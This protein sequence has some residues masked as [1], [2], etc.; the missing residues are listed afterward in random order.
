VSEDER[1]TAG[2][3]PP[4]AVVVR[5]GIMLLKDL[6]GNVLSHYDRVLAE[7]GRE[8]WALSVN[9]IPDLS[10]EDVARRAG[11]LNSQICVSTVGAIRALDYEVR[12]D[13]KENGHSNI[14]FD[15]EPTDEDLLRVRSAFSDPIPNPARQI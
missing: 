8:E 13:W 9:C 14:V 5:G 4:D 6:Q 11:R 12:P 7:E 15:G 3:L 2:D 10:A 1:T